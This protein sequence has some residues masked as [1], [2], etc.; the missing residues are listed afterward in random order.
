MAWK[1]LARR[2]ELA[3]VHKKRYFFV[4]YV[5]DEFFILNAKKEVLMGAEIV[6]IGAG[7]QMKFGRSE[8]KSRRSYG[9]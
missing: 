5:Q 7:S 9:N 3:A 4:C 1:Q 8:E 6:R 2:A